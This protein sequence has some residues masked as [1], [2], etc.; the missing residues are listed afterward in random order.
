MGTGRLGA[1]ESAGPTAARSVAIVVALAFVAGLLLSLTRGVPGE[2]PAV[3]MDWPLLLHLFRAGAVAAVAGITAVIVLSLWQVGLPSRVA[4][5]GVEWPSS[6]QAPDRDVRDQLLRVERE[7]QAAIDRLAQVVD[8]LATRL[9]ASRAE[10]GLEPFDEAF[11]RLRDAL[12][13]AEYKDALAD[14][15]STLPDREKLVVAL[16]FYEGLSTSE[17]AQVLGV[18][19]AAVTQLRRR[20]VKHLR[21]R[22]G[23]DPFGD[24]SPE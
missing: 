8:Q 15:M 3:S 11:G 5:T 10:I 9:D 16:S 20:G 12:H 13:D 18:S 6:L 4:T 23:R 7:S 14:A 24:P 17:I 1:E 2:L 22:L 19:E 21:D